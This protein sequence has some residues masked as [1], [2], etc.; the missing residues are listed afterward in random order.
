M[1]AIGDDELGKQ[2]RGFMLF[3]RHFLANGG[4]EDAIDRLIASA[5]VGAAAMM[6]AWPKSRS[7]PGI[8]GVAMGLARQIWARRAWWGL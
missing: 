7:V 6:I 4:P 2:L 8:I 1:S 3:L 5:T